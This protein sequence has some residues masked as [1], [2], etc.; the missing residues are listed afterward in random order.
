[1]NLTTKTLHH[2]KFDKTTL[3][4]PVFLFAI[5]THDKL[6]VINEIIRFFF[7]LKKLLFV[8]GSFLDFRSKSF[9]FSS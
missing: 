9:C 4:L 3:F 2:F 8:R 7:I 6:F 5:K 1:M